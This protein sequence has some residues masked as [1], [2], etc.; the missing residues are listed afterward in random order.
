MRNENGELV[1]GTYGGAD[2]Q[3]VWK[4][5]IASEKIIVE[6]AAN[7]TV[8]SA[9]DLQMQGYLP[10]PCII[11]D[12]NLGNICGYD[13]SSNID[14]SSISVTDIASQSIYS[15]MLPGLP[16][17]GDCENQG[18]LGYSCAAYSSACNSIN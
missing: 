16:P 11:G 14:P 2:W 3:T 17:K 1:D 6:D 12:F 13:L 4:T 8:L 18:C 10:R 15:S 7:G 5:F 9:N